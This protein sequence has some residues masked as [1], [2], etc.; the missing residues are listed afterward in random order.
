MG[1]QARLL[2]SILIGGFYQ[3]SASKTAKTT[4][5]KSTM[6]EW[7]TLREPSN[8]IGQSIEQAAVRDRTGV[9][10]LAVQRGDDVISNPDPDFTFNPGDIFVTIGTFEQQN[11][12][13][14]LLTD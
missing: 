4:T 3:P 11:Q 5:S 9:T 2:G 1:E 13:E 7:Q 12:L 8:L 14:T 6:I 10:I